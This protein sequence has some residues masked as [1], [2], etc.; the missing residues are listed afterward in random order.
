MSIFGVDKPAVFEATA[1][2]TGI[3]SSGSGTYIT[4]TL[5]SSHGLVVGDTIL[6]D[7]SNVSGHNSIWQIASVTSTEVLVASSITGS[8][9]GASI[10]KG[11]W[12]K[13]GIPDHDFVQPDLINHKSVLTGKKSNTFLGDYGLFRVSERL[14]QGSTIVRPTDTK[15]QQLYALYHT[16]VWFFP[17][18]STLTKDSSS[19][20]I[21]CYFKTLKPSYYKNLINYDTLICEFETNEYY[22]VTKLLI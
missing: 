6:A 18:G 12:F 22:D 1:T 15:F 4:F 2:F 5:G 19:N 17:H 8:G 10:R 13:N 14:W 7:G 20:I 9:T 11:Y 3:A 21:T 16:D